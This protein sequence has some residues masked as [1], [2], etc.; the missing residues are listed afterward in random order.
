MLRLYIRRLLTLMTYVRKLIRTV[1]SQEKKK[2]IIKKLRSI[3]VNDLRILLTITSSLLVRSC[4]L[5][6]LWRSWLVTMKWRLQKKL[7][8]NYNAFLDGLISFPIN[9]RGTAYHSCLQVLIFL[10]ELVLFFV[11]YYVI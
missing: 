6:I 9:I 4:Y 5:N 1:C 10:W 7:K 11:F 3:I 8:E 2:R